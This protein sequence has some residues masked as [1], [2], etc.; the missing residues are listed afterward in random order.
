MLY[1][2]TYLWVDDVSIFFTIFVIKIAVVSARCHGFAGYVQ[3][4]LDALVDILGVVAGLGDAYFPWGML[5][6]ESAGDDFPAYFYH[7]VPDA[8]LMENF[9]HY[10]TSV[11]FGDS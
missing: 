8:I 10:I 5:V 1:G 2:I 4:G 11:A 9:C 3:N 7:E 6:I